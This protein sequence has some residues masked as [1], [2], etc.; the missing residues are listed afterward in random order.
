MHLLVF[1]AV[2]AGLFGLL[3]WRRWICRAPQTGTIIRHSTPQEPVQDVVI[4]QSADWRSAVPGASELLSRLG[5]S[6]LTSEDETTALQFVAALLIEGYCE[7]M[8]MFEYER[9]F[10]CW[11]CGMT[12]KVQ[13]GRRAGQ[14]CP[15]CEGKGFKYKYWAP[16]VHLILNVGEKKYESKFGAHILRNYSQKLPIWET[17]LRGKSTDRVRNFQSLPMRAIVPLQHLPELDSSQVFPAVR[18]IVDQRKR[19]IRRFAA[20]AATSKRKENRI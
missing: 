3:W 1:T 2:L 14:K 13:Q 9:E 19:E 8:K 18:W 17:F 6:P 15:E 20:R 11:P 4:D 5:N 10:E 16:G 7:S 12:G